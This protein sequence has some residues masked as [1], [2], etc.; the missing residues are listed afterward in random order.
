MVGSRALRDALAGIGAHFTDRRPDYVVFAMW[1]FYA[2]I[3]GS[4]FVY[5]RK[6]PDIERPYKAWGYP[7][8]P[9]I[10]GLIRS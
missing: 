6:F 1:I 8:V 7:V 3:T 4:I 9:I 5:R 2:L 10:F